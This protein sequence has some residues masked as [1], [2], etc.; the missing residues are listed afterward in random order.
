MGSGGCFPAVEVILSRLDI[1]LRFKHLS[2]PSRP[3]SGRR[4]A[5]SSEGKEF[6]LQ[7]PVTPVFRR[8]EGSAMQVTPHLQ[9][10]EFHMTFFTFCH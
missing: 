5:K 9:V 10:R 6:N 3:G 2:R 4:R 7:P 8:E 1:D